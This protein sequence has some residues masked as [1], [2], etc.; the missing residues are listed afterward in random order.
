L[1]RKLIPGSGADSEHEP[2]EGESSDEVSTEN[3]PADF[4]LTNNKIVKYT[5]RGLERNCTSAGTAL[6]FKRSDTKQQLRA[7]FADVLGPDIMEHIINRM[8]R[9]S[10]V[11]QSLHYLYPVDR[12]YSGF[13]VKLEEFD[14]SILSKSLTRSS[15]G[16]RKLYI[17]KLHSPYRSIPG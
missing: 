12:R 10:A 16:N 2:E 14:G 4:T 1:Q 9:R 6:S 13:T 17:S 11:F 3:G 5:E 8:S 7:W 15:Q